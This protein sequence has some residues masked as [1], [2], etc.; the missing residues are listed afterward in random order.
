M[1]N[2]KQLIKGLIAYPIS[3]F[4]SEDKIDEFSYREILNDLIKAKA[5]AIAALGSTAENSYLKMSEW[6]ALLNIT[7]DEVK[8][9]LPVIVGISELTTDAAITKAKLAEK[10][11]AS[12]LMVLTASYWKL[13]EE[14]IYHH[15]LNIAKK[16]DLPIMLYNNPATSGIDIRPELIVKIFREIPNVTMVKESSA[17]IRRMHALKSLSDGTLPFYCGCNSLALEAL[18]IGAAGWCT[19][20]PAVIGDSPAKLIEAVNKSDLKAAKEIFF[21]QIDFYNF[22][23]D[24]GLVRAIKAAYQ[25]Q[26]KDYGNP[27]LPLQPLNNLDMEKLSLIL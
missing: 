4:N 21:K 19:C 7:L 13:T 17:D 25:I 22:I 15:Y 16:T 26:G 14:E 18:L 23:V 8:S 27:R 6:E 20:T 11:G 9:K 3:P 1:S 24:H 5:N 12:A 2:S 10:S